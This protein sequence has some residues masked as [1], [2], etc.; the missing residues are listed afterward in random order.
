MSEIFSPPLSHEFVPLERLFFESTDE[1][2]GE[3]IRILPIYEL[4]AVKNGYHELTDAAGYQPADEIESE[5]SELRYVEFVDDDYSDSQD[6][7]FSN[8]TPSALGTILVADGHSQQD[9]TPLHP[10]TFHS[11]Y[12]DVDSQD[13]TPASSPFSYPTPPNEMFIYSDADNSDAEDF[14]EDVCLAEDAENPNHKRLEFSKEVQMAERTQDFKLL[15]RKWPQVEE[16]INQMRF[17][18]EFKLS[19]TLCRRVIMKSHPIKS[20]IIGHLKVKHFGIRDYKCN[21][22]NCSK[23]YGNQ[24]GLNRH[25]KKCN[26]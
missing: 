8:L 12:C 14:N 22:P 11:Q 21:H 19:C 10:S 17:Q 24:K 20:D 5:P 7:T 18:T 25:L 2:R 1:P 15:S 6:S 9:L 3:T 4:A 23:T 26:H 16:K 13:S